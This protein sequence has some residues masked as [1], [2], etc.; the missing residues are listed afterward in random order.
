MAASVSSQVTHTLPPQDQQLSRELAQRQTT[1]SYLFDAVRRLV[2]LLLVGLLIAWLA[3][4]WITGPAEKLR[5]RPLPSLGL[6][7]VGL[8]VAPVAWFVALGLIILVAVIFGLLSLGALTVLTLLAGFSALGLASVAVLLTLCYL[9]Q[10]IVAYLGGLWLVSRIRP[11]W[12]RRVSAPMLIGLFILGLLSAVPIA[13]GILQFVVVVA[14]LGAIILAVFLGRPAPQA[15]A[16]VPV[17]V[18]A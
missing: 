12:S 11:E 9:C 8:V 10:A 7:L 15:P 2:A 17:T 16:E 6:G 18:Q 3:P 13:G 1:S 4:R 5:S 14:G